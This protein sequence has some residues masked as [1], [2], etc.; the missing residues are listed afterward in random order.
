MVAEEFG[1]QM[2]ARGVTVNVHHF[3]Q[4][5]PEQLPSA[6]LY[7]FSSPGALVSRSAA[8]AGS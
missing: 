4:A 1:K 6:D 7:L 2:A 8:C 3:R 5:R